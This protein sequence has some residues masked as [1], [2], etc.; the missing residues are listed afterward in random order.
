MSYPS[1]QEVA[2]QVK[3]WD[4]TI[5]L[6]EEIDG[7]VK[8]IQSNIDGQVLHICRY[9]NVGLKA[10]LDII[11]TVETFDYV[12]VRTMGINTYRDV[13]YVYKER[14]VFAQKVLEALPRII[15]NMEHPDSVNLGAMV[16]EHGILTWE[17]GNSLP[18]AIGDF[19]LYI[20]P[21][22]AI[23]H[24]NGSVIIID[25]TD[26]K[27]KDQFVVYYNRLRNQFFAELKIAGVFRDSKKFDSHNLKTLQSKL[28]KNLKNSLNYVMKSSHEM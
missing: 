25:Y 13:R 11:Y 2:Q 9:F 4:F 10:Q 20:K 26:F 12:V 15:K 14:D 16:A 21:K 8:E 3:S 23:E 17:Y 28:E 6:P 5:N 7:F 18:A 19:E 27:R 24:I 1:I 22:N